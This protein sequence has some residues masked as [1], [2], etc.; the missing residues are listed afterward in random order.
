MLAKMALIFLINA[1]KLFKSGDWCSQK[2]TNHVKVMPINM[3][4]RFGLGHLDSNGVKLNNWV[5]LVDKTS[6][7]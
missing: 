6:R 3:L 1:S 4:I 7:L 2:G 5:H